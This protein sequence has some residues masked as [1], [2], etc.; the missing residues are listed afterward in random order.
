MGC[1]QAGGNLVGVPPLDVPLVHGGG[2][3]GGVGDVFQAGDEL[4]QFV[5]GLLLGF[6]PDLV[7][8]VLPGDRFADVG[9]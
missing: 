4:G 6:A 8:A 3:G 2:A 9:V 1:Y 7:A 5:A